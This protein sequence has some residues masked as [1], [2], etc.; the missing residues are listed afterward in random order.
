MLL[1]GVC[2]PLCSWN[3][4]FDGLPVGMKACWELSFVVPT[5]DVAPLLAMADGIEPLRTWRW[6]SCVQ[7]VMSHKTLILSGGG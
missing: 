4:L 7:F 2:V 1:A 3:T 6:I 5:W